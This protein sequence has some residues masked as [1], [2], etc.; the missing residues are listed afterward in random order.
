MLSS[1]Q[2]R[3]LEEAKKKENNPWAICTSSVG[4]DDKAKYERCVLKVKKKTGY[5]ESIERSEEPNYGVNSSK[6]PLLADL[7][8]SGMVWE[9]KGEYVGQS[10]DGTEIAIGTIGYEDALE[11]YLKMKPGPGDW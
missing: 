8:G 11:K 10:G 5:K 6:Y 9:D 1:P 4:R 3:R 2:R 7:L